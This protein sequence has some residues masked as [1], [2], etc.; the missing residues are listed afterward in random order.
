ME[1][2]ACRVDLQDRELAC[3]TRHVLLIV[4]CLYF[5]WV[6]EEGRE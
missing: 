5:G 2:Q 1:L 6:R 3:S 4:E